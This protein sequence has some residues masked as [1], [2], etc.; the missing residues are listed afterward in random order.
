[1]LTARTRSFD[2][3][4][5]PSPRAQRLVQ[6]V[7]DR[8][9]ELI[10]QMGGHLGPVAHARIRFLGPFSGGGLQM[11]AL[12]PHARAA[13]L[14]RE[15]NASR[16]AGEPLLRGGQP[17]QCSPASPLPQLPSADLQNA[18]DGLRE[19]GIGGSGEAPTATRGRF[20]SPSLPRG[21]RTE[22]WRK[23][24]KHATLVFVTLQAGRSWVVFGSRL[25]GAIRV[26]RLWAAQPHGPTYRHVERWRS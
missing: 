17:R 15:H 10:Y 23:R 4:C 26:A 8:L 5:I 6:P 3:A 25:W 22:P 7:Y 16:Q 21:V 14:G 9:H 2:C 13:S 18:V 12:A 24:L 11:L 20:L 1:M 19:V